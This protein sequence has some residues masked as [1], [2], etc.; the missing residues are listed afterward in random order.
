MFLCVSSSLLLKEHFLAQCLTTEEHPRTK[1]MFLWCL[2]PLMS[3][4]TLQGRVYVLCRVLRPQIDEQ[5]EGVFP[6][7]YPL[8]LPD[9]LGD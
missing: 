2:V 9:A 7:F 1:C 6:S 4:N 8:C 5:S 3:G